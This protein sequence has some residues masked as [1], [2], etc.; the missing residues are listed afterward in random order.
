MLP[1]GNSNETTKYLGNLVDLKKGELSDRDA[2]TICDTLIVLIPEV[3]D[4]KDVFLRWCALDRLSR[5]IVDASAQNWKSRTRSLLYRPVR[6]ALRR[7]EFIQDTQGAPGFEPGLIT[8]SCEPE[9]EEELSGVIYDLGKLIE[10]EELKNINRT[11]K[12][13][14]IWLPI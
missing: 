13:K 4:L 10:K 1:K 5:A 11:L 8:F 3:E 2:E 6:E 7:W 9:F 14:L 12:S